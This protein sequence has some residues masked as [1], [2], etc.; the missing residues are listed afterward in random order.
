[1]LEAGTNEDVIV[2]T[3]EAMED[4]DVEENEMTVK[5]EPK[6]SRINAIKAVT[7]KLLLSSKIGYR[8]KAKDISDCWKGETDLEEEEIDAALKVINTLRP[9]LYSRSD[10]KGNRS[11]G[12]IIPFVILANDILTTT[13][14]TDM[15]REISPIIGLSEIHTLHLDAT[16]MFEMFGSQDTEFFI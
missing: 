1:M 8:A 16:S 5:K 15:A 7:K 11:A 3:L 6:S 12:D 2:E 10:E 4:E 9:Y 14:Y 13:R